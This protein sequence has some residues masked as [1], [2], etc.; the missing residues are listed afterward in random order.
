[1]V[2]LVF[3]WLSCP[4]LMIVLSRSMPSPVI[5]RLMKEVSVFAKRIKLYPNP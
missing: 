4:M 2:K 5:N 1:M 3:S